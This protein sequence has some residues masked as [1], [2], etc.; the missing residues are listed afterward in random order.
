MSEIRRIALELVHS[1]MFGDL[2]VERAVGNVLL[3]MRPEHARRQL[4]RALAVG[5]VQRAAT[6]DAIIRAYSRVAFPEIGPDTL[7]ALRLGTYEL[8]FLDCS[9]PHAAIEVAAQRVRDLGLREYSY[10]RK[11]LNEVWKGAGRLLRENPR[12]EAGPRALLKIGDSL[13]R[14][15]DRDVFDSPE[16][17]RIQYLAAVYSL[18][19]WLAEKLA[20][21]YGDS[22]ERIMA[23]C[24]GKAPATMLTNTLKNSPEE[25]IETLASQGLSVERVTEDQALVAREAVNLTSMAAYQHG[26]LSILDEFDIYAVNYLGPLPGERVC[27][28]G[29]SAEIM[30]QAAQMAF[31]DGHVVGCV[32]D[33][34]QARRLNDEKRRLGLENLLTVVL[35]TAEAPEVLHASF[36][37]VFVE[38]PNSGTGRLRRQAA[39]RWRIEPDKLP[40]IVEDGKRALQSAVELCAAGGITVYKTSSLLSEENGAVVDDVCGQMQHLRIIERNTVFP[41]P[42]GRDGGFIAKIAK[43]NAP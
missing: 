40:V 33:L 9:S 4:F 27:V 43:L 38:P 10:V 8:V 3:R 41:V 32:A 25:L 16:R 20:A 2:D 28:L 14:R 31:P 11:T 26:R 22:A 23:G 6:L 24:I 37:R 19:V 35:E 36:D 7:T 34:E 12:K 21:Q 5:T 29:G 18:P 17:R 30:A 1:A 15:F 39:A 13:W 42:A